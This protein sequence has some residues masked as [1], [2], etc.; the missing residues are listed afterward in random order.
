MASDR[1]RSSGFLRVQVSSIA[2]DSRASSSA[3]ERSPAW[4]EI[5]ARIGRWCAESAKRALPAIF[6]AAMFLMLVAATIAIRF[7][8]WANFLRH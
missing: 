6:V 2:N 3:P 1:N 8:I 4:A 5:T 7:V